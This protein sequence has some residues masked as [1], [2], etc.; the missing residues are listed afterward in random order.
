[1]LAIPWY[2]SEIIG[3][4]ELFGWLYAL[5][6]FVMLFWG[7]YAGTLIDRFSRKRVFIGINVFGAVLLTLVSMYGYS[8]GEVGSIGAMFVFSG[9]I[10][11]YNIHYPALYA[12]GQ[13]ITEKEFYGRFTS[14]TET[15][16]QSTSIIS[17][18]IGA[19][20]LSGYDGNSFI[21]SIKP[22]ELH[23]IFMA[24]AITYWLSI[25]L[26]A[27]IK[28]QPIAQRWAENGSVIERI[29]K[30]IDYL[31]EN[32]DVFLFGNSSYAI[33]IVLLVTV[34]QLLPVYTA[35]QL[36][37]GPGV[38]A[39]AELAYAIGAMLA[40]IAIIK[41]FRN[42]GMVFGVA[43][44]M[45]LTI[46]TYLLAAIT[47]STFVYLALSVILGITN[48]GARVMRTTW[49]FEHVPNQ[50]IGRV[51]SVFQTINILNRVA[52]SALCSLPFFHAS[53][54]IRYAYF[55]CALIVLIYLIPLLMRYSTLSALKN[56]GVEK[57]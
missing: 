2:F 8:T 14:T 25:V 28:Y 27:S 26:I 6:T 57:K 52:L 41:L 46:L 19:A 31:K 38:Y 20:L 1:M 11:I 18:A 15:V 37:E 44:M 7:L 48:A 3:Q 45:A 16:G 43:V 36:N 17:G 21:P 10:L 40:G 23:E 42:N 39:F 24:D 35:N 29:R 9:T 53:N 13:E 22:W 49:L 33:F 51:S 30:G 47:Q 32:R 12:F 50:R 34:Q 5:T 55:I 4:P 54:N 56:D